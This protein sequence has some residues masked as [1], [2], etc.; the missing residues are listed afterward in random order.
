MAVARSRGF[1]S[2]IQAPALTLFILMCISLVLAT[3]AGTRGLEVTWARVFGCQKRAMHAVN[4][5][6]GCLPAQ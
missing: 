4:R 6:P 1:A 5:S 3:A 2:G